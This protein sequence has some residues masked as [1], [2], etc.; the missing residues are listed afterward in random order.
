MADFPTKLNAN[1]IWRMMEIRNEILGNNWPGNSSFENAIFGFG[2]TTA[3]VNTITRFD[4]TG[5]YVGSEETAG[6]A[7]YTLAA[8]SYGVDKVIFGFGNEGVGMTNRPITRFDNTG[9]YVSEEETTATDRSSL[10]A[11]TYGGDKAMFGFGI[12]AALSNTISRFD[13]TG[14][15]VGSEETAGT[16]RSY[17]GAASYGGDKAIFGFGYYNPNGDAW[18]TTRINTITRFDNTGTYVGSEET[19]GTSRYY[20]AAATYGRDKAIFGFGF[21]SGN[22]NTITRFDNTGTYVGSEETAGTARYAVAAAGYGVENAIFG[23]GRI[24]SSSSTNVNTINR[25]DNTGSQIGAE[26]TAGSSRYFLAA[27]SYG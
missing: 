1:G 25:F 5:T 3:R 7:R 14:T 16:A 10:A 27:A 17:L 21:T 18:G 4:N 15:Y 6:L 26:D 8:A 2:Y 20:V 9:T 12:G 24:T 22:S 23:F 11:A 13:N 19:A